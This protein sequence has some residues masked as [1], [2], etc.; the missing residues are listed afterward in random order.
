MAFPCQWLPTP[1]SV[2]YSVRLPKFCWCQV[3]YGFTRHSAWTRNKWRGHVIQNLWCAIL[4]DCSVYWRWLSSRDPRYVMNF[5]QC[6]TC[7]SYSY[8]T[9]ATCTSRRKRWWWRSCSLG[10][11]LFQNNVRLKVFLDTP[12][13]SR[14]LICIDEIAIICRRLILRFKKRHVNKRCRI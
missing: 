7:A 1:C 13:F 8:V 11:H 12:K 5:N 14:R 9:S 2:K 6:S 4:F 3:C 10:A